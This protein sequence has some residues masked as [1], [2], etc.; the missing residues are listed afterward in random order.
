MAAQNDG[1]Y[2]AAEAWAE[3]VIARDPNNVEATAMA[4][5]TRVRRRF[6]EDQQ[7]RDAKEEGAL[8]AFLD[9]DRASIIDG[10]VLRNGIAYPKNFLEMTKARKGYGEVEAYKTP[11]T[12]AVEKQLNEP[13]SI[14]MPNGTIDEAVTFL[15]NYTGLNIVVDSIAMQDEALTGQT[16]VNLTLQDV[17]IKTVLKMMLQPYG[18]SYHIEDGVLMITT[19]QSKGRSFVRVYQVADLVIAPP[20]QPT[21]PEELMIQPL[22]VQPP[23]GGVTQAGYQPQDGDSGGVQIKKS[24]RD[25]DFTPLIQ[26]ITT[27]I[28]PGSWEVMNPNGGD[29]SASGFGLGG[30]LGGGGGGGFGGLGEGEDPPIGSITPFYLNISLIIRHTAEV[31]DEVVD[32]LRQLRRLQ[33]L[34]VSVEVRFITVNDDFFEFIGVDFDFAIQSDLF[35]PKSS[36]VTQNPASVPVVPGPGGGTGGGTGGGGTTTSHHRR[37]VPRQPG[38]RSF[39]RESPA[40]DAR[41]LRPRGRRR[42]ATLHAEH[43]DPGAVGQLHVVPR[44]A[45]YRPGGGDELRPGLPQRPRGLPLPGGPPG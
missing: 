2:A 39:P 24:A 44:P 28:A 38:P 16:A 20:R 33:D 22:N 12:V 35:G 6:E 40:G 34:Q 3:R 26:L 45:E 29:A 37:P 30:G 31:H 36:F 25:I 41:R 43:G 5:V 19:P 42:V 23:N 4:T 13:I 8:Q 7:I 32:L 11:E 21:T 27:S 10:D 9:V 1:D 17:P 15:R 18:L 14:S